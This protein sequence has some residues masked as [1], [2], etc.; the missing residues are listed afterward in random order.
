M[1]L[2]ISHREGA[3]LVLDCAIERKAPFSPDSVVEEFAATLKSYRV[4]TVTGDRYAGEWPRERFQVHG[5]RY[6][7]AELNRS[8]LYLAFL[9][10]VNSGRVD[11]LD[12]PRMVTQFCGLERRTARSGKDTVDHAPGAH[13]DVANAVAGVIAMSSSGRSPMNINAAAIERMR[14][15]VPGARGNVF[16]GN[17]RVYDRRQFG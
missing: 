13:D 6:E 16:W 9:P 10:L 3:K 8:E 17:N 2:A 4:S 12:S 1:T 5:V 15:P 7:A 11:L 14:E